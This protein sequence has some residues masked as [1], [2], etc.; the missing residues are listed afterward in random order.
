[1][2]S[3]RIKDLMEKSHLESM[4]YCYLTTKNISGLKKKTKEMDFQIP[5]FLLL[6][7]PPY[8]ALTHIQIF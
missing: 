5:K 8:H 3:T 6:F 1:M 4:H 7:G 2:S